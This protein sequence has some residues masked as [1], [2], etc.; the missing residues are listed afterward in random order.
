MQAAHL[1]RAVHHPLVLVARE[2]LCLVEH[3]AGVMVPHIPWCYLPHMVAA[4]WGGEGSAWRGGKQGGMVMGAGAAG[5]AEPGC[6]ALLRPTP[7]TSHPLTPCASSNP[8][9]QP[10]VHNRPAA[11]LPHTA[12]LTALERSPDSHWVVRPPRVPV[13][14]LLG[15]A[16]GW[17][18]GAGCMQ[19]ARRGLR[20][21][22]GGGGGR[23]PEGL[24]ALHMGRVGRVQAFKAL[25]G[26]AGGWSGM[27][28][29][30][31]VHIL[32]RV[33]PVHECMV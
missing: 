3:G 31:R 17:A 26:L 32:P 20:A 4:A 25:Y 5:C 29:P 24:L 11:S 14:D 28:G 9:P 1:R 7:M 23:L 30:W 27:E 13:Q 10:G 22:V 33:W 21:G 18:G 12:A 2:A 15:G 8:Q 16:G 6:A 19:G